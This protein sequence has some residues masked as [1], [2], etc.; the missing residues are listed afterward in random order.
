MNDTLTTSS[1]RPGVT[2]NNGNYTIVDKIG[3]G[4]FGITY[5]AVQNNLN[6]TVC[7]KEYFLSGRC[8]R[9][10]QTNNIGCPDAEGAL[11]EKY[12]KGFV[13]E[14]ETV[15]MLSHPNVVEII[16]IFSENN[17][18]YMVMP[19]IEGRS[20]ESIVKHQ[21]PLSFAE[22]MNYLAQI[23]EAVEYVHS[24]HILHRDIKP[25]NIM[26]TLEHRAILIDFGSAREFIEDATQAH[27]SILTHGYAPPEQ[28][29]KV[30]RKG[31]YSDVYSLGATFYYALTGRDPVDSAARVTEFMPEPRAIN[32]SVPEHVN[33]AIMRA[34]DLNPANRPQSVRDF[35]AELNGAP[36][37]PPV[38]TPPTTPYNNNG[39]TVAT[40]FTG[41]SSHTVPYAEGNS[42][43][44]KTLMWI[45]LG[46]GAV[47][48]ALIIALL[49]TRNG[50][51]STDD[52]V[53]VY[54]EVKNEEPVKP[55]QPTCP[56]EEAVRN[57]IGRYVAAY[58]NNDFT[59]LEQVF[60][61]TLDRFYDSTNVSRSYV[62]DDCRRYDS[63]YK[64]YSKRSDILWE[65]FKVENMSDGSVAVTYDEEYH[66]NRA[67]P[68][69]PSDFYL[70]KHIVINSDCQIKS[71]HNDDFTEEMKKKKNTSK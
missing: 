26:I 32:P 1:L 66:L 53:K 28:Y 7:I 62:I 48:L 54:N 27:T 47:I 58:E 42:K 44:T 64:V 6:R 37:T 2:L 8:M 51:A 10:T 31:A 22:A 55:A 61:P 25:S 57:T 23:A 67:N 11:Y 15:A 24:R 3:Q 17:T 39:P 5:R 68:K 18:S 16:N 71:I 33:R 59:T 12:R 38:N 4:G 9:S 63:R 34:M 46:G 40:P 49:A 19:F 56:S 50:G 70:R 13:K 14:A 43:N 36:A 60:A 35:V 29:S 65:T 41:N 21:G 69:L 45:L 30:S 20:L 52:T